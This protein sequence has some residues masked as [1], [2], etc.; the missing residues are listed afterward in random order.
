MVATIS[1]ASQNYE[2]TLSTLIYASRAKYIQ[3]TPVL[4]LDPKDM[5]LREYMEEIKKLKI[6]LM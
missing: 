4:N 5:L 2:E 6:L 1:M 3:N